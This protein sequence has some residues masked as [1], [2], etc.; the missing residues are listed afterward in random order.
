MSTFL[1]KQQIEDL[2]PDYAFGQ[3]PEELVIQFEQS[4]Q[5]YPDL[6]S[7]LAEIKSAFSTVEKNAIN[8]MYD[9]RTRNLSIKV[10][11]RLNS[12]RN[13]FFSIYRLPRFVVPVV[14]LVVCGVLY[15]QFNTSTPPSLTEAVKS[16]T[17]DIVRPTDAQLII[18]EDIS[19]STAVQVTSTMMNSPESIPAT[20]I[21]IDD[22]F[23]SIDGMNS[24]KGDTDTAYLPASESGDDVWLNF[25]EN[26]L[27]DILKDL[28]YEN[29]SVL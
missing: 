18:D 25:T 9:Q 19:Y 6:Q 15:F 14:G 26:E 20:N 22:V 4:I 24:G 21:V 11:D 27:Q 1:T 16:N 29:P 7:Q 28:S 8:S 10:I 5:L 13:S 23:A 3:L 17:L 12:R 2:L